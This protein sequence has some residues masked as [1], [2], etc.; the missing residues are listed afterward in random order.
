MPDQKINVDIN[1]NSDALS[2][3]PKYKAGFD[4]LRDAVNNLNKE[5]VASTDKL[6]KLNVQNLEAENWGTKL[7]NSVYNLADTYNTLKT[8]IKEVSGSFSG[9]AGIAAAAFTLITTYGPQVLDFLNKMF[10][11][12]KTREAAQALREY[13]NVMK[14]YVENVADNLSKAQMLVNKAGNTD[15]HH[16]TRVDALKELIGLSPKLLEG[17]TLQNMKTKEGQKII[18]AYT[19]SLKQKALEES[20]HAERAKYVKLREELKPEFYDAKSD[21]NDYLTGKKKNVIESRQGHTINGVYQA[22][23]D[24]NLLRDATQRFDK[25][26]KKDKEYLSQIARFDYIIAKGS[27]QNYA[28]PIVNKKVKKTVT[29]NSNETKLSFSNNLQEP[30]KGPSEED[31]QKES[32][33]RKALL[34]LEGY[35]REVKETNQHFDKII[36]L[37]KANG[38]TVEQLEKERATTLNNINQ[39]FYQESLTE[40]TGYE[41]E[42]KQTS[43]NA[44]EQA[45]QQLNADYEKKSTNVQQ[46]ITKNRNIIQNYKVEI[47]RLSAGTITQETQVLIDDLTKK[48]ADAQNLINRAETVNKQLD[49]KHIK[50]T[51]KLSQGFANEDKKAELEDSIAQD[52]KTG[53]WQKEFTDK[54]ALL[55]LEY[56]QAISAEGLKESE[57]LRIKRK[58]KDDTEQLNKAKQDAEVANQK[59][60]LQSISSV[61]TAVTGIF[62]KNTIAARLAFKAQQAAAAAQVII[63]TKKSIMNIWSANTG[64]P[65]VGVPKAIAETALVAAV[66]ASNL[67][68]IIKQKPGF[69]QGGQ[70]V[71]DGRGALLSGYSRTDNTNA[72]LRS[73]EAVVV[74][75]A[76][77]NPWA[78]NL[79]SAINVAHG[80]RDF[81]MPNP[82]R[83][84]AI[85]GIFTDGGNANRYYSQPVNDQKDM[86]NTLAYQLINN[87]PP[88][89]VDV[90]DVNNQQ[91]ILAQTVDRVNL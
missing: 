69:S 30:P 73:G 49:A 78:R 31:V 29:A 21:R 67:A 58:Y 40:L 26:K 82:G 16:K 7:K 10:Q 38:K 47:E 1:I 65:F 66:G 22:G 79:V 35:A 19:K 41:N 43:L 57:L 55:K 20:V 74:S 23:Y 56:D 77:R 13:K 84:Y 91:N 11:S 3:L 37:H 81:S 85:G 71:S 90:K 89:Y 5:I 4:S 87:F 2:Q 52:G 32:A 75:E 72:Y 80:G 63:E 33:E 83:G 27:V 86:A 51:G 54:Q 53:N 68:S 25:A 9:W 36:E 59:K 60:Y 8:A 28:E 64:I 17:L 62:G 44:R 88:I 12:D 50:D 42:L 61:A 15:L 76:M 39:K 6:S 18:D 34:V 45:L 48:Q 70:Y 24:I 14:G 46:V